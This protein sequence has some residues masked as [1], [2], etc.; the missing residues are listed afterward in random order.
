M[1]ARTHCPNHAVTQEETSKT[2][3]HD[4]GIPGMGIPSLSDQAD[5]MTPRGKVTKTSLPTMKEDT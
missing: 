2:T 5:L 1:P 4:V 3:V